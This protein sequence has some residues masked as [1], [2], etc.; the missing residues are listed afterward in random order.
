MLLLHFPCRLRE[1]AVHRMERMGM[2]ANSVPLSYNSA[3]LIQIDTEVALILLL[4]VILY[5]WAV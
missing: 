5:E 3:P 4:H 1:W 2:T